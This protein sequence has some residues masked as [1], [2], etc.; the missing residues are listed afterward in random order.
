MLEKDV[1]A[2][3]TSLQGFA[4]YC[5]IIGINSIHLKGKYFKIFLLEINIDINGGSV[6][7]AFVITNAKIDINWM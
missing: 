4:H 5:F 3:N 2:L 7:V 1:K 6:L